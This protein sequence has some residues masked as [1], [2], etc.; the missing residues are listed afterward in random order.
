MAEFSIC[1]LSHEDVYEYVACHIS[2]WQAAFKG[3]IP[4]CY[5]ENLPKEIEE[6]TQKIKN[7]LNEAKFQYYYAAFG[8]QMIGRL[9]FGKCDDEDKPNAGEIGALYLLPEFWGKGFGR[10]MMDFA[11][12][13]LKNAGHNEI[14]LWVLEENSRG[15]QFYEGYGFSP[16]G[17]KKEIKD[18]KGE[19]PIIQVRYSLEV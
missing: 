17:A 14:I 1:K 7:G 18:I 4:D 15:R 8:A 3:I 10:K 5:L 16:D 13:E 9:I 12:D 19:R 6:R 2:C 11:V